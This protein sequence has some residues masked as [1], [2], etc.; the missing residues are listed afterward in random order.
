[1]SVSAVSSLTAGKK[2]TWISQVVLFCFFYF[3]NL[4]RNKKNE[5]KEENKMLPFCNM[6]TL[7]LVLF[8]DAL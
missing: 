8:V 4:I 7:L 2:A 5:Q 6:T 3:R 1:M